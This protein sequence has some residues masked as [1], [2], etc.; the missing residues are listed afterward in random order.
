MTKTIKL[1][2]V[3]VLALGATSAFATNGDLMIGQGAKSRSM[4]G[5]GIAKAFGA[6]SALANPANISSVKDM[7]AT[8]AVTVFMP[9]VSF[10]G[11]VNGFGSTG[12]ADSSANLSVIPEIYYSARLS[13]NLVTGIAIAGTAGMGVDYVGKSNG[14]NEMFSELS[15]LK[16]AVPV[17]YSMGG[18]TFGVAGILQYGSLE[19]DLISPVPADAG[20]RIGKGASTDIGYGVEAGVTYTTGGLTLGAVYKSKIGMTYDNTISTALGKFD[21]ILGNAASAAVTSGDNLDQPAERG[22]GISYVMGANTLSADYKNIAYGDAAGYANFGWE[23][24]DVY[25]VGYEYAADTWALRAGYNYAKSPIVEQNGNTP[26]G[27]V[28][29]FFNLA[30]FP[31]VIETHYAIGGGYNI[32]KDFA[33]DGSFIYAPETTVTTNTTG[34]GGGTDTSVKHSQMAVTIAGTYAF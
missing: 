25:A 13:E 14:S 8:L 11:P 16:V 24:Q 29:N 6:E 32:T 9:T 19:I 17:S 4:G 10:D 23:D 20:A 7:E 34:I 5:V 27:A 18:L 2:V 31:G 30:G 26:G 21:A 12:Y 28:Q 3:A 1:A 33:L 22:V 15:L